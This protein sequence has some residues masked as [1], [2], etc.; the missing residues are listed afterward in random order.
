VGQSSISWTGFVPKRTFQT[1]LG[2]EG[3]R[4]ERAFR[5]RFQ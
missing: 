3:M 2:M 1:D 5:L 4:Q